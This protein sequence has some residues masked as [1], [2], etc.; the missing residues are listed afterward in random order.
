MTTRSPLK[1]HN[2]TCIADRANPNRPPGRGGFGLH[3]GGT[4]GLTSSSS[5]VDEAS[6]FRGFSMITADRFVLETPIFFCSVGGDNALMLNYGYWDRTTG[7]I[8]ESVL[9]D[10]K[11]T[12]SFSGDLLGNARLECG[13][14]SS[15]S[16]HVH[17]LHNKKKLSK[18]VELMR[19]N[20]VNGGQKCAKYQRREN[21]PQ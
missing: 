5:P 8:F 17:E 4:L 1:G 7:R 15:V 16:S 3:S 19:S 13:S 10:E 20:R 9:R 11:D 14:R 12:F 6:L 21:E 2:S 18:S